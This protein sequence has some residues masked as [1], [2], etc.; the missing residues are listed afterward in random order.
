MRT[1]FQTGP[2]QPD[3]QLLHAVLQV[4]LALGEQLGQLVL[5]RQ[6]SLPVRTWK[7]TERVYKTL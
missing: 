5:L 7:R 2:A 4:A 3:L 1:L 6:V